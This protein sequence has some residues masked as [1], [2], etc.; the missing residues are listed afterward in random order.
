MQ[1]REKTTPK[2]LPSLFFSCDALEVNRV[3]LNSKH[4]AFPPLL[5]AVHQDL[6]LQI[7]WIKN[8]LSIKK[9]DRKLLS[10]ETA[11]MSQIRLLQTWFRLLQIL[12]ALMVKESLE[13]WAAI[14]R[15]Q[16]QLTP[17]SQLV[18]LARKKFSL[19]TSRSRLVWSELSW[20]ELS[21]TELLSLTLSLSDTKGSNKR[22][23]Q[24]QNDQNWILLSPGQESYNFFL[25][26]RNSWKQKLRCSKE[27]E[28][29][30]MAMKK[31]NRERTREKRRT[32]HKSEG[33]GRKENQTVF[34]NGHCGQ[35]KLPLQ[36][37]EEPGMGQQQSLLILLYYYIFPVF[38]K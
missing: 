14:R 1:R 4:N 27:G 23:Q 18:S 28:E 31:R 36:L 33:K 7:P 6:A 32:M 15:K 8:S 9:I 25:L 20:D 10:E 11:T 21:W 24:A 3:L 26:G 34:C 37:T 35:Q 13:I 30:A 22:N 17:G 12:Q 2:A 5:N 29:E 19:L 16:I 38:G